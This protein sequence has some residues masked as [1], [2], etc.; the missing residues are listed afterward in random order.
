MKTENSNIGGKVITTTLMLIGAGTVLS[1]LSSKRNRIDIQDKATDLGNQIIG[2][3]KKEKE[4]LSK[5]AKDLIS[6]ANDIN[7]E[8][9]GQLS[10]YGK[11]TF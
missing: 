9:D 10:R 4:N 11:K 7:D 6:K 3:F 8:I 5:K 2:I 1:F